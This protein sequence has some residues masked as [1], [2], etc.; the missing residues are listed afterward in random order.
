MLPTQ[1]SFLVILAA[2]AVFV[3]IA[4][5]LPCLFDLASVRRWESGP[6]RFDLASARRWESGF[7]PRGEGLSFSVLFQLSSA[8][9]PGPEPQEE[10]VVVCACLFQL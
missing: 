3:P 7:E 9:D 10:E 6:C 8:R 4:V 2:Y 1:V 5:A